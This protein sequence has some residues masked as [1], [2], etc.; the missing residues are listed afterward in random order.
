MKEEILITE[1]NYVD[2]ETMTK[3]SVDEEIKIKNPI[4]ILPPEAIANFYRKKKKRNVVHKAPEKIFVDENIKSSVKEEILIAENNYV[5]EETTTK[6]YVDEVSI[7]LITNRFQPLEDM[8]ALSSD[9][10]TGEDS[11]NETE[12]KIEDHKVKEAVSYT[13]LTLP[14]KA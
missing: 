13:H 12:I 14:T 11:E 3:N 2:E 6:N 10:D 4:R 1:K 8:P 5:D 7:P 9:D